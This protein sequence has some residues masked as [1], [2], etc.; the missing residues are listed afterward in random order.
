MTLREAKRYLR[1]HT[2]AL[3]RSIPSGRVVYSHSAR[4]KELIPLLTS[5]YLSLT[6]RMVRKGKE[7]WHKVIFS[8]VQEAENEVATFKNDTRPRPK[9]KGIR[10]KGFLAVRER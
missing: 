1:N 2:F 5:S 4:G 8:L 6:S 9:V 7:G 3:Y 10:V